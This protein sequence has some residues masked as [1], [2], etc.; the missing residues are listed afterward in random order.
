M[1]EAKKGGR[2]KKYK[3]KAENAIS[4]GKRGFLEVGTELDPKE[5]DVSSLV[6]KG[7]AE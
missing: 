2:P 1:A 4:D 7:L 3:V 6:A 5:C